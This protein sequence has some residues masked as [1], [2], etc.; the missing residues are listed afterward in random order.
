[1]ILRVE[2]IV[3]EINERVVDTAK[4]IVF[5]PELCERAEHIITCQIQE[6]SKTIVAQP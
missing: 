6:R 3:S 4:A 1:M 2:K 5:V